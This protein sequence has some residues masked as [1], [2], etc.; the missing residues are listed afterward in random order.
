[1]T[2]VFARKTCRED[3]VWC[4]QTQ[5]CTFATSGEAG[6][7]KWN[8]TR[9]RHVALAKRRGLTCGVTEVVAMP[10]KTCASNI[11]ECSADLICSRAVSKSFDKISW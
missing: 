4:N 3:E 6:D 9:V 7:R 11:G 8:Q 10:K 2:E 5:L 1:M